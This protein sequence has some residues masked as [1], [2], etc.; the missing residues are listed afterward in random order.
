MMILPPEGLSD[1]D[2]ILAEIPEDAKSARKALER[3]MGSEGFR[4]QNR[5]GRE[6]LLGK[7]GISDVGAA[8]GLTVPAAIV[9]NFGR[10]I[11]DAEKT[12]DEYEVPR[13]SCSHFLV[14]VSRPQFGLLLMDEEPLLDANGDHVISSTE[15][16][17][18]KEFIE[19]M[20]SKTRANLDPES[21][22][23]DCMSF[24][25]YQ[26]A[27]ELLESSLRKLQK[28][29]TQSARSDLVIGKM[30]VRAGILK[31]VQANSPSTPPRKLPW[32]PWRP[33]SK[34]V[35]TTLWAH[36]PWIGSQHYRW[37]A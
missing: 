27:W 8:K 11:K 34:L 24:P 5:M 17:M 32:A 21:F 14:A 37:T 20:L 3:L 13:G 4:R 7:V 29:R 30:E 31:A 18:D 28:R 26:N 15:P 23:D 35:L 6:R 22:F 9:V 12:G 25:N 36:R 33:W 19:R 10:S 2:Q 1:P 16:T